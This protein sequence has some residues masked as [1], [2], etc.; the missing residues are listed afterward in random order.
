MGKFSNFKVRSHPVFENGL[1]ILG[2]RGMPPVAP[3]NTLTAFRMAKAH[4]ANGIELDVRLCQSGELVV[5]HDARVDR[6]TNGRGYVRHLSLDEIAKLETV[7]RH[8]DVSVAERIPTLEQVFAEFAHCMS[9]NI[10]IKGYPRLMAGVEAKILKLIYDYDAISRVIVSSFNPIPLRRIRSLD[11]NIATGFLIDRNF[12][13][14]RSEK[15]IKRMAG[16]DAIH[17]EVTLARPRFVRRLQRLGLRTVVWG[18]IDHENIENL[19]GLHVDGLITDY[20]NIISS[21]VERIQQ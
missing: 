12:F 9:L 21:Y 11:R 5:I 14:R 16:I 3:E 4:G 17:L 6:T 19:L 1:L 18:K 15:A 13:I 8:S 10:E 2:H 7:Y 20:P